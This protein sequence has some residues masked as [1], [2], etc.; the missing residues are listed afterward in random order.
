MSFLKKIISTLLIL[1]LVSAPF[2]V[3]WQRQNIYDTWRLHNYQPPIAVVNLAN[4]TTMNSYARKVFYVEQPQLQSLETFRSNCT[5]SEQT[6]VLGCYKTKIGIYVYDVADPRLAGV[7]EV[8]AAH[9]MLHAAY[10]RLSSAEKSRINT[11][12]QQ[13]YATITDER[14]KKNVEAYREK[15][16]GIVPNELHSILGTEVNSLPEPLESYYKQYFTNRSKIVGYSAQYE[17]EFTNREAAVSKYDEQLKTMKTTI[18]NLNSSLDLQGKEIDKE[19]NRLQ[20]LRAQNEVATYNA[21]IPGYQQMVKRY[22]Q[23][24]AT[25]KTTITSYNTIV[26]KRNAIVGEEK[27]LFESL[28]TRLPASR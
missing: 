13:A 3:L 25:L 17:S 9:E 22:N 8:T 4:N 11:L 28:D 6:I 20:S 2:I 26:E 5:T 21:A 16:P 1:G 7:Q 24:L 14:I 18:E 27:S 23:D 19:N 10:D 15:D 12:T